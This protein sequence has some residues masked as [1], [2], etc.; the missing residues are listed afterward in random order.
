MQRHFS[1]Y[2]QEALIYTISEITF[3]SIKEMGI[4]LAV[5]QSSSSVAVLNDKL[6]IFVS[7]TDTPFSSCYHLDG[8]HQAGDLLQSN[9]LSCPITPHPTILTLILSISPSTTAKHKPMILRKMGKCDCCLSYLMP[10]WYPS[11]AVISKYFILSP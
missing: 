5:C 10:K 6:H 7:S 4:T 8:F 3:G 9:I 2:H 11:R 1:P